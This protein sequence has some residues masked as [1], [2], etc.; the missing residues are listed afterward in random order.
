[1]KKLQDRYE[2]ALAHLVD[3]A[4]SDSTI[5]GLYAYGSSVRGDIWKHSDID[6]VFI[7]SDESAAWQ[8]CS[9]V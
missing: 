8:A 5:I 9:L 3:M 2:K 7:S 1:M 4:E 6:V